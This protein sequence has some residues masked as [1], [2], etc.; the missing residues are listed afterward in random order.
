ME[1]MKLILDL[2]QN[3]T[4]SYLARQPRNF[5]IADLSVRRA[6]YASEV[7]DHSLMHT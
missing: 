3:G 1:V 7:I 6:F 2:N 5:F 4:P